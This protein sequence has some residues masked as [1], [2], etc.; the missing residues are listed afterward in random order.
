MR[1]QNRRQ[2]RGDYRIFIGAF[3][4]GK[5][6]QKIQALREEIDWKTSQITPPH[7]TL[8]GTYWRSG[9][10][11]VANEAELID[12]L[13]GMAGKIP[14]FDLE[15]GGIR[16]FGSR[17]IYL[18]VQPTQAITVVRKTLL[19]LVGADK[20]RRYTPHLTLAMRL[21]KP[22]F[23]ATVAQLKET[24]WEN[25]RFT[26]PIRQLHLMQRGPEDPAWRQ[27]YTL[28]LQ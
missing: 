24:K 5:L 20:H 6:A 18:G 26:V 14:G 8:A 1:K 22:E 2:R 25:G 3:P 28:R 16:T 7:V 19:K 21:K 4:E 15:L 10:A 13:E 9:P 23:A 17:V 27:I 11:T 12:R